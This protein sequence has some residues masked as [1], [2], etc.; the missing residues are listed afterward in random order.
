MTPESPRLRLDR[1]RGWWKLGVGMST[2]TATKRTAHYDEGSV[3]VRIAGRLKSGFRS[4]R[5][6]G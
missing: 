3:T 1:L 5:V 2:L 6:L 4:R